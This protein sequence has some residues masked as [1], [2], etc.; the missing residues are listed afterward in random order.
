VKGA[1]LFASPAGF[2]A[3]TLTSALSSTVQLSMVSVDD[4]S[5]L[6]VFTVN[7]TRSV[8]CTSLSAMNLH[9]HKNGINNIAERIK[10][11]PQ[12]FLS[13]AH[14]TN[15]VNSGAGLPLTVQSN[16]A[17]T[18]SLTSVFFNFFVNTGGSIGSEIPS[19][20]VI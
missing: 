4:T 9:N 1:L 18:P 8:V 3:T 6:T 13:I 2:L 11:L 14:R 5:L 19:S 7:C 16:V 12:K 20:R 15:Q 10:P 17:F